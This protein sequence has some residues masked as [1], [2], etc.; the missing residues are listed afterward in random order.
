MTPDLELEQE[1]ERLG[2]LIASE[3]SIVDRVMERLDELPS[4]PARAVVPKRVL[5]YSG[6]G[7]AAS[8]ALV[9]AGYF[10][11]AP[12]AT[13]QIPTTIVQQPVASAAGHV[14]DEA[15]WFTT[16]EKAATLPND[17]P[18]QEVIRQECVRVQWHDDQEHAT[19][20]VTIRKQP[21]IRMT[22]AVY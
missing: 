16:T 2:R 22:M 11:F 6:A 8:L 15:R 20:Q 7:L 13:S 21:A 19:M 3:S 17:M 9:L 5:W 4:Q 18:V 12:R 10:A 14:I 1:L